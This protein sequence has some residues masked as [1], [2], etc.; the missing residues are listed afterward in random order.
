MKARKPPADRSPAPP[1]PPAAQADAG[2]LPIYVDSVTEGVA[3]FAVLGPPGSDG[4][5]EPDAGAVGYTLPAALL[6]AGSG[7]GARLVLSVRPAPALAAEGHFRLV[8]RDAE[9]RFVTVAAPAEGD[10]R[11]YRLPIAALPGGALPGG[12]LPGGALKEGDAVELSLGVAAAGGE[13]DA[14][15]L[16]QELGRADDGDDFSI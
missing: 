8:G 2:P 6:P 15:A 7:E 3:R 4:Q 13:G 1:A 14:N 16:R 10:G 5:A 9:K 11:S 12:A